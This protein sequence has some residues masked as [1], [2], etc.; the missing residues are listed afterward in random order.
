VHEVGALRQFERVPAK[1]ASRIAESARIDK[2]M[3]GPPIVVAALAVHHLQGNAWMSLVSIRSGMASWRR[4]DLV[5]RLRQDLV[6]FL[7]AGG[8]LSDDVQSWLN[9]ADATWVCTVSG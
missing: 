4:D 3:A 1:R 5:R 9:P 6:A 2:L 7:V 8:E